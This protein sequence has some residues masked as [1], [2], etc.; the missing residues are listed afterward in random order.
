MNLIERAGKRL[1]LATS[2]S[3]VEKAAER[4][5]DAAE[6]ESPSGA[7]RQETT[8]ALWT[9]DPLR[10]AVEPRRQTQ[11]QITLDFDRLHAM[12]FTTPGDQST[13]AEEFRLIKRPLLD[14]SF[15][16]EP[17]AE[18]A[19]LL[20]VTSAGP[21]EGK[22]FVALNLAMSMASEHNVHV[23]LID[24]DVVNPSVPLVL[25]FDAQHGMIDVVR[26]PSIELADVMVR[27]NIENL[28]LLPAGQFTPM[29]NELLASSQMTSFVADIAR[30]YSDRIIIF[31]SPPVL[32]RTEPTVLARH[33]GQ[34]VF[35][36]EAEKTSR[37]SISDALR[38]I[39]V[40]KSVRIVLNKVPSV[41][42][43]DGFGQYYNYGYYRARTRPDS[44]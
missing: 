15:N 14:N 18:N 20:M 23:L 28:T 8:T 33:V 6:T 19:N 32:A 16:R 41:L 3:L 37:S 35:V 21:H 4:L 25:G 38:L 22:T 34:I 2:K 10:K 43:R 26:D 36:V 24:A 5:D 1:G 31:D 9:S 7:A 13:L 11:R 12:G 44:R 29:A 42:T 30:R 39:D 27:T 40:N 17:R